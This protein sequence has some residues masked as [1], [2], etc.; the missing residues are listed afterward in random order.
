MYQL[1]ALYYRLYKDRALLSRDFTIGSCSL[2]AGSMT[3][4]VISPFP[5]R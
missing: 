4:L 2:I 1:F 5:K 3:L